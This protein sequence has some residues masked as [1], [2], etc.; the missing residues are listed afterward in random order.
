MDWLQQIIL[1]QTIIK[2]CL[3]SW[4]AALSAHFLL[5]GLNSPAL[6]QE[7]QNI[8]SWATDRNRTFS[9]LSNNILKS[10]QGFC[11]L[12]HPLAVIGILT[13]VVLVLATK[14]S[15]GEGDSYAHLIKLYLPNLW[16]C[17]LWHPNGIINFTFVH[18]ITL[19]CAKRIIET[20]MVTNSGFFPYGCRYH[21]WRG[22]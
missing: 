19:I 10:M 9:P 22:S 17:P 21:G 11:S 12:K 18:L 15:W 3:L 20:N 1:S 5:R 7:K 13:A 4:W 8:P 14:R 6:V 16:Q 2:W